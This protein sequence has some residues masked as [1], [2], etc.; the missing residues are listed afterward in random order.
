MTKSLRFGHLEQADV[1]GV[2][3]VD[4]EALQV[5]FKHALGRI[6]AHTHKHNYVEQ[7]LC[8]WKW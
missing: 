7:F 3:R 2:T 1:C 4:E 6:E 8:K 5:W